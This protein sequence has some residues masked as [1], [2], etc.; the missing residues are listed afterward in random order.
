[1]IFDDV[2]CEKQNNIRALFSMVSHED[3]DSSY[4]C[5]TY[6]RVPKHSVRGNVNF[7]VLFKQDGMNM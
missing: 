6:T 2:V 3:V 7:I 4:L 1:M 5:Q